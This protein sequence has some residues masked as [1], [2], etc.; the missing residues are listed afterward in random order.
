MLREA[1]DSVSKQTFDN[2]EAIIVDDGST[3]PVAQ[4]LQDAR[5]SLL[6]HASPIGG[7]AGKNTGI[8]NARGE[9]LAFLDDDD[10]YAPKYLERAVE[11]L[12]SNPGLDVVFMGVSWFGSNSVWSQQDYDL[13]MESFLSRAPGRQSGDLT[14]FDETIINALL[15]SVPM[16]LQRPVVRKSA[17]IRIGYYRAD[18]LL[19]DCDWAIRAALVA[20]LAL[21]SKGLYRQRSAGQGYSSQPKRALDHL[22]SSVQIKERIFLETDTERLHKYR[23]IFRSA[24]AD[25]WLN[26]ARYHLA[27][28]NKALAS[29]ALLHSS[30]I[31]LQYATMKFALRLLWSSIKLKLRNSNSRGKSQ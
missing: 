15:K 11:V 4:A 16:A 25:A 17:F 2:W 13:A 19:W 8:K 29:S 14:I 5:V 30:R 9:I 24:T 18:C 22:V 10:C 26:L 12:D 28:G 23:N 27:N 7:A 1:L 3:P 6:R 31:Q 20:N 21:L